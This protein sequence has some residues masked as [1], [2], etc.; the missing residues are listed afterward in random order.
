[1]IPR[2]VPPAG[3]PL[4]IRQVLNALPYVFS[5]GNLAEQFIHDLGD[6]LGVHYSFGTSSG[7]AALYVILQGLRKLRPDRKVVAIPA[8]VCFSVPAAIVRSGLEVYPVEIDPQTLDFDY[9]HLA[10]IPSHRLL[11][12]LSSNLFGMVNDLR[13]I[14]EIGRAKGAFVVD[15]AAQALGSTRNSEMAGTSGDVGFYSFGRGKALASLEGGMIVTNSDDIGRA[16]E[17]EMRNLPSPSLLNSLRLAVMSLAYSVFLRPSLYGIPASLPWLELGKTEFSPDFRVAKMPG[18]SRALIHEL[19]RGLEE[20]NGIRRRNA[21]FLRQSVDVRWG[22]EIPRAA[23]DCNPCYTRL[24]LLAETPTVKAKALELFRSAGI[25]A[26]PFYPSAICDIPQ[27]AK[28]MPSRDYHR[29]RAEWVAERL[30]TLPT[31][32]FLEPK[33]LRCMV[34]SLRQVGE[35]KRSRVQVRGNGPIAPELSDRP[36]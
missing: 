33:D 20:V 36:L 23:K 12:I 6:Q 32:A 34:A 4:K 26:S 17:T 35:G 9:S 14:R 2:L 13:R 25:G 8:Y 18:F 27:L 21:A 7:R 10:Q 24:P 3:S 5:A 15:D 19:V 30:L 11:C 31:H 28:H 29:S 1:M 16:V 22:F